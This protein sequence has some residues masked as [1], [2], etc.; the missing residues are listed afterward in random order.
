MGSVPGSGRSPGVGNGNPLQYSC[1][2]IPWTEEP[3]RLWSIGSQRLRPPRE[4]KKYLVRDTFPF[5]FPRSLVLTRG[6]RCHPDPVNAGA[7]SGHSDVILRCVRRSVVSD[8][9]RP[10]GLQSTR[11]L[12]PWDSP[13]RILEWAAIPPSRESSQPRD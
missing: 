6:Q 11:L 2:R 4:T 12:R 9:L 3:G 7:S 1:W 10:R 5:K 8:S 13:A